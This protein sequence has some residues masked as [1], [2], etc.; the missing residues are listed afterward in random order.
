MTKATKQDLAPLID[1]VLRLSQSAVLAHATQE[2]LAVIARSTQE[3][4]FDPGE[5]LFDRGAYAD[6][7]YI[8]AEG[9]VYIDGDA[10]LSRAGAG[11][12]VGGAEVLERVAR[13]GT[14]VAVTPVRAWALRREDLFDVL[15]DH[16]DLAQDIL[17]SH[18]SLLAQPRHRD[19][20]MSMMCTREPYQDDASG[21]AL[22]HTVSY[23]HGQP[24]LG[25]QSVEELTRLVLE[26]RE[27]RATAGEVLFHAGQAPETLWLLLRGRVSGAATPW[28]PGFL[29]ALAAQPYGETCVVSEPTLLLRVPVEAFFDLLEDHFDMLLG[30]LGGMSRLVRTFIHGLE[31]RPRVVNSTG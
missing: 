6:R 20:L 26:S 3:Q 11:E 15:E 17:R 24:L 7:I 23:L 31:F 10:G 8:L 25:E 14:A 28:E 5:T 30:L 1:R 21:H 2:Q 29:D 4:R 19:R 12:V 16:F 18:A 27:Q 9:A 13:L 22:V